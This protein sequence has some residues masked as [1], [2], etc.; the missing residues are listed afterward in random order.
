MPRRLIGLAGTLALAALAIAGC[1][2]SPSP[3]DSSASASGSAPES[4][5]LQQI[6]QRGYANIGMIDS[7]PD[8]F[9]TNGAPDGLLPSIDAAIFKQLGVN[10]T[11][12]VVSQFAGLVPGLQSGSL[13]VVSGAFFQTAA[14][15]PVVAFG[16][17]E[18]VYTYSFATKPGS[19]TY[20]SLQDI[21]NSGATLAVE[22]ATYQQ[23]QATAVLPQSQMLTVS[24]RQDGIDAVTTGRAQAYIAPT[25]TLEQLQ[26]QNNNDYT[27]TKITDIAP[28]GTSAAFNIT[29][30]DFAA[31]YHQAYEAIKQSGEL[32]QI[33]DKYGASLADTDQLRSTVYTCPQ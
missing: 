30:K 28:L 20:S 6:K 16:D 17:V 21:K 14:R 27:I 7:P 8:S 2:S 23:Q 32:E 11:R 15:C 1:S 25:R 13:D 22:N 26:Q 12:A 33:M 4:A 29:N 31:E 3:S 24:S 19:P 10:D 9:A 18:F 5:L